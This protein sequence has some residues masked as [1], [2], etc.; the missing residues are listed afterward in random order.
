MNYGEFYSTQLFEEIKADIG[1]N[2]EWAVAYGMHPAVLEYNGIATLTDIW[3]FIHRSIKR[4]F[5]RLSL[6]H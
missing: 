1:Y 4:S 3:A 6:L 5:V 2:G